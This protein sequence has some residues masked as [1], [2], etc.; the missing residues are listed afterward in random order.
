MHEDEDDGPK[1][2]RNTLDHIADH[3]Y[4]Y[5][6]N[7]IGLPYIETVGVG[8]DSHTVLLRKQMRKW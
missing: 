5:Y 1:V 4:T 3:Y 6:A 8:E 2:K 7:K